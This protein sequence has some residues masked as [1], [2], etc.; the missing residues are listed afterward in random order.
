MKT[1]FSLKK[2]FLLLG[3]TVVSA[4]PM[5]AKEAK[6]EYTP[7]ELDSLI[8]EIEKPSAPIITDDYIIF[9]A[10]VNHRNVGIAFDF[11]N[12]KI[13][14]PYKLLATTDIDG[15]K[16]NKHLFYCYERQ[17]K[18]TTI[19]YRLIIDGLWTTD[20]LNPNK[21]Y[22]DNVNLYFS[23]I[24]DPASIIKNT[25]KTK[26]DT[27]H[28]V[29]K[30]EKG[31]RL[32]LAGTFTNWDPWIYELKETS[33]GF[34]ELNLPL[35]TGKYY[36]NYYVG[37]TPIEDNTNPDKVYSPDGRTASVIVVN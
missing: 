1:G 31:L 32:N 19:K 24:E 3:L 12:Y 2:A 5:M 10:D 36:Y 7:F 13:V 8:H 18:L 17:H 14:H 21:I 26:D 4:V 23:F 11:E 20:P 28:F 9:T 37:L 29:Y 27:V 30:G 16:T 25:G 6:I 33:P 15:T 22:D 34:Y 35:P